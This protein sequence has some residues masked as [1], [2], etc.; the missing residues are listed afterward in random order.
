MV[1]AFPIYALLHIYVCVFVLNVT[2]CWEVL[3]FIL[4]LLE[5][6]SLECEL[7]G[8]KE[9]DFKVQIRQSADIY[10]KTLVL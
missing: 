1:G 5:N 3:E 8:N 9:L 6:E 4:L 10:R 2:K 7:K